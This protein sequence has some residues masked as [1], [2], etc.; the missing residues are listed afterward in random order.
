MSDKISVIMAV[1]NA[2]KTLKEAVDSILN[3]TYKNIEF[4]I[5]DDAS[6]DNSYKLLEEY[7]KKDDRIILIK[8]EVN[9][10]LSF[11][12]NHCL[13]YAT[14]EYVARMDADDISLPERLEKQMAFLKEN[15]EYQL[16]GTAMQRFNE[17]GLAD[18]VYAVDNPDYYTLRNK[19][20]FHHATILTE[21]RMYDTVNGYTVSKRTMRAQDYD[22]WF[23]FYANGFKGTNMRE[24]LYL[25]REDENAI[26]R[27]TFKV[28]YNAFKTTLI[29]FKLLK[30][31]KT[32]LIRP[33]VEM[34]VKS[35]VPFKIVELY[36]A[37]Q[38]RKYLKNENSN[39]IGEN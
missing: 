10:R 38:K 22:L 37:L 28:R 24:A 19:I 26:R 32:W 15:P 11:S 17:K 7:A 29:G 39:H 18:I 16:V 23:R 12:L 33:A 21:K 27:R 2:E 13:K 8:N 34:V 14:G 31:P 30:Y 6:T 25:V 1:Y 9:S 4:I 20:P 35:I 36:R 5:C 3:Q